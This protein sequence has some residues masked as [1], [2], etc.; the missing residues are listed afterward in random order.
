M[1][2]REFLMLAHKHEGQNI[3]GWLY[4]EKLDGMRCFWDG[5]ITR[6]N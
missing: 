2:K 4:S 5:G 1:A 6:G 3:L